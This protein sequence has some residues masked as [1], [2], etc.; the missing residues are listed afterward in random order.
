MDHAIVTMRRII[1]DEEGK[2]THIAEPETFLR[3]GSRYWSLKW[4]QSTIGLTEEDVIYE[5]D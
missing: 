5:D 2:A 4:I 3:I 1:R